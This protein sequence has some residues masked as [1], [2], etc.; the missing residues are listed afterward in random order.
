LPAKK[1]Q[2][3]MRNRDDMMHSRGGGVL[4]ATPFPRPNK[5]TY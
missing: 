2:A 5:L 1:T 4:G 3:D